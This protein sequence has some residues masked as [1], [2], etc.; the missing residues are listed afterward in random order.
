M[1]RNWSSLNNNNKSMNNW[2]HYK[3]RSLRSTTT[4]QEIPYRGE[5]VVTKNNTTWNKSPFLEVGTKQGIWGQ[6]S[7]TASCKAKEKG[8]IA[9]CLNS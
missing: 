8:T 3:K 5:R 4:M 7:T 9:E 1:L 2:M 6:G